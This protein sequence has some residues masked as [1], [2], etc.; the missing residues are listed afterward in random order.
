MIKH[1]RRGN[2][3]RSY[4]KRKFRAFPVHQKPIIVGI[5]LFD[6][7]ILVDA[8]VAYEIFTFLSGC[9]LSKII[10]TY[11]STELQ[12]IIKRIIKE[13]LCYYS[14][15]TFIDW[16]MLTFSIG[17]TAVSQKLCQLDYV[18]KSFTS[19]SINPLTQNL[20]SAGGWRTYFFHMDTKKLYLS[21]ETHY[22]MVNFSKPILMSVFYI[23]VK[24][25]NKSEYNRTLPSML[26]LQ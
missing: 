6:I 15:I 18:E 8:G 14:S 3:M 16:Q 23:I 21:G 20:C 11:F 1:K 17:N 26:F 22:P 7:K 2:I 24:G 9:D 10:Q 25:W 12:C 13:R 19:S 4:K 5:P